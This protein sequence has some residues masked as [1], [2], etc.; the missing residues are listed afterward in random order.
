[1]QNNI[2]IRHADCL[3]ELGN[4]ENK[5]IDLVLTD[6]PY[7]IDKYDDKWE[8]ANT[9]NQSKERGVVGG[10]PVG[11]KFDPKD[12]IRLQYFTKH[13]AGILI[14]TM[15]PGAFALLFSQPRL[16]HRMMVGLEDAGFEIRDLYCWF[17]MNNAQFKAFSMDHFIEKMN[18]EE[19]NK[20]QLHD[21]MKHL[22]TAQIRPQFESLVLAQKPKEGT[23]I[24]NWQ[25]YETGLMNLSR[26]N[27]KMPTTVMQFKKDKR[28]KF[29]KH[30][31]VKPV[32]LMEH[33]IKLFTIENQ[34]VLDP[35]VG[36]GT[37]LL[38]AKHTL[39]NC[40]GIEK[41]SD[42]VDIVK[43]RLANDNLLFNFS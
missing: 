26:F 32:A 35:F 36:S 29:N 12:G 9:N 10:M 43:Q 33:L 40:I 30:P 31:T 21:E 3:Q 24:D 41:N 17:Y 20:V 25:K 13:F 37:T 14:D 27:D 8:V 5:S 16:V 4:I 15:K 23:H 6:P 11:M 2:E 19:E 18:I 34:T 39:R 22:K 1:M 42:Y 28:D 7:F 38:A